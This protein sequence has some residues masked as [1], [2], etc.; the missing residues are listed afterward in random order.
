MR[1]YSQY[2]RIITSN[3]QNLVVCASKKEIAEIS[4]SICSPCIC[5]PCQC[6]HCH[7][8]SHLHALS[9]PACSI[10][11]AIASSVNRAMCYK[12]SATT[13]LAPEGGE[14]GVLGSIPRERRLQSRHQRPLCPCPC[15][16]RGQS[17]QPTDFPPRQK[18]RDSQAACRTYNRSQHH[19][20]HI[21]SIVEW[22]KRQTAGYAYPGSLYTLAG[23]EMYSLASSDAHLVKGASAAVSMK[24]IDSVEFLAT[25]AVMSCPN[26]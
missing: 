1:Y 3:L 22:F 15:G 11:K 5:F 7:E 10:T 2:D 9:Q 23:I 8:P 6:H 24:P 4:R 16:C 25:K 26:E 18:R 20:L 21:I 19:C 14:G 17:L 13:S 12:P